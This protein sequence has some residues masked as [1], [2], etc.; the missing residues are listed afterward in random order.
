MDVNQ[1]IMI[2]TSVKEKENMR[3]RRMIFLFPE[4]HPKRRR[5]ISEG[6]YETL[7]DGYRRR[8]R[9]IFPKGGL[10]YIFKIPKNQGNFPNKLLYPF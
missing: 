1:P 7:K 4:K 2:N 3:R 5:M 9:N 8:R 10:R 6:K